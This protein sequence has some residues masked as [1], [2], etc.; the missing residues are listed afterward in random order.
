MINSLS[1]ISEIALEAKD[2]SDDV[3]QITMSIE[4]S[5]KHID[6]TVTSMKISDV[7]KFIDEFPTSGII[8]T[9]GMVGYGVDT[10]D[11]EYDITSI[12]YKTTFPDKKE[13]LTSITSP[14]KGI[15]VFPTLY[16][17]TRFLARSDSDA[18]LAYCSFD[19]GELVYSS[20]AVCEFFAIS[21]SGLISC[22][23]KRD[24]S[25]HDVNNQYLNKF[26]PR[27]STSSW[28]VFG[29]AFP[30][31]EDIYLLVGSGT[32]FS[33]V[34]TKYQSDKIFT[35]SATTIQVESFPRMK[36]IDGY[37]FVVTSTKIIVF[38]DKGE[39]ISY[40]FSGS[41]DFNQHIYKFD[42]SGDKLFI[43]GVNKELYIYEWKTGKLL[44]T[45]DN[46]FYNS[47]DTILCDNDTLLVCANQSIERYDLDGKL[48]F[49]HSYFNIG[50][51]A[52]LI[53][54]NIKPEYRNFHHS[55]ITQ[56]VMKK[57]TSN[58]ETKIIA[59]AKKRG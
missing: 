16:D 51:D 2:T 57:I 29:M 12:E 21:P 19:T 36:T 53:R 58:K 27:S 32:Q 23:D 55:S 52:F 43:M 35:D 15:R 7:P 11:V 20:N 24:K 39:Q 14:F 48:L 6:N 38:N 50:Y 25:V 4:A 22:Y 33:F 3:R 34:R 31:D 56:T 41:S 5:C 10:K 9:P 17:E 13:V 8:I 40:M 26:N 49:T 1:P 47:R 44:T 28:A 46:F 45:K 37:M 42:V 18:T 59:N 30:N 54:H